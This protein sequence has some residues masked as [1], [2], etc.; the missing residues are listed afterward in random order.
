MLQ[1]FAN[2]DCNTFLILTL[3]V[4]N[5]YTNTYCNKFLIL[6]PT[7]IKKFY[8]NTYCNIIFNINTKKHFNTNSDGNTF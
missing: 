8:V 4:K 2:T 7:V 6:T 3:T 1:F 5:F